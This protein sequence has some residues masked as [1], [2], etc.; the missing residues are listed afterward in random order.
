M[1]QVVEREPSEAALTAHRDP[2]QPPPPKGW[3]QIEALPVGLADMDRVPE[4]EVLDHCSR[5]GR[6]MVHVM[7]VPGLR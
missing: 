4:V 2:D 1:L 5:V 3:R 6:V 7:P